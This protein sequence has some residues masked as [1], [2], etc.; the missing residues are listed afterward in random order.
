M[1]SYSNTEIIVNI[2]NIQVH[3]REQVRQEVEEKGNKWEWGETG[4]TRI[5]R[6]C[7]KKWQWAGTG[8]QSRNSKEPLQR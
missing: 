5:L 7:C 4:E 2:N 3:K 1:S 6:N 8:H